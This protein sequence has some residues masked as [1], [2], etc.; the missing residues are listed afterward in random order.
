[1][2]EREI[3]LFRDVASA[4]SFLDERR[5]TTL[6]ILAVVSDSELRAAANAGAFTLLPA[7]HAVPVLAAL[8][9]ASWPLAG[10]EVAHL[11][12][13]EAELASDHRR[14]L[15]LNGSSVAGSTL[16]ELVPGAWGLLVLV[17]F[18]ALLLPLL[19][20]AALLISSGCRR[21]APARPP[22][23]R[24]GEALVAH[25]G[26]HGEGL[27]YVTTLMSAALMMLLGTFAQ[28]AHPSI[29][30][31]AASTWLWHVGA[32][33]ALGAVG[34]KLAYVVRLER[35]HSLLALPPER[36]EMCLVIG[37]NTLL[38]LLVLAIRSAPFGFV[39]A[40]TGGAVIACVDD[41]GMTIFLQ[42][43]ARAPLLLDELSP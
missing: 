36:A 25:R 18:V 23:L 10:V 33:A 4:T 15:E 40:D 38:A 5:A 12:P 31:C 34:A 3:A 26:R 22:G 28:L 8:V 37:G 43:M 1:M 16:H 14:A 24:A 9:N 7:S 13:K 27:L 32:S 2:V 19:C 29:A 30:A 39:A 11:P 21:G 35:D 42:V 17:L 20:M 41:D 6:A